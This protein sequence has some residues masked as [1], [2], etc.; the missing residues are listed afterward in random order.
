MA[1]EHN[2]TF[3]IAFG[4]NNYV[5][6]ILSRDN[7]KRAQTYDA[8]VAGSSR[9]ASGGGEVPVSLD[10]FA[11]GQHILLEAS[12]EVD[13]VVNTTNTIKLKPASGQIAR[14]WLDGGSVTA[15][16]FV[17]NTATTAWVQWLI[18]GT[19]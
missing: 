6:N 4:E 14:L 12:S 18:A 2:S 8:A 19:V 11:T 5:R 10:G 16:K 17:N 1:I 13:V 9:V 3:S 7:V 15:L